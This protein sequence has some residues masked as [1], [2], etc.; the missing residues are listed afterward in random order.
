MIHGFILTCFAEIG[1]S[2]HPCASTYAGPNAFSEPESR[3]LSAFLTARSSSLIAYITLHSY[4]QYWL[5]PWGFTRT[6]PN[7]YMHLVKTQIH[8]RLN[9]CC[10]SSPTPVHFD[11]SLS[12]SNA[13]QTR[14]ILILGRAVMLPTILLRMPVIPCRRENTWSVFATKNRGSPNIKHF[15]VVNFSESVLAFVVERK[16]LSVW[17][18]F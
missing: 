15:N 9:I 4:G 10:A 12:E 13:H 17:N 2:S 16:F 11:A 7:D 18:H 14:D 3:A 1:A 5:T 8:I 6:L